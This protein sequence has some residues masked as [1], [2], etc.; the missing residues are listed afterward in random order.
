[1]ASRATQSFLQMI[2]L[3]HLIIVAIPLLYYGIIGQKGET[4]GPFGFAYM[5]LLGGMALVYHGY[6]YLNSVNILP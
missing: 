3:F 4:V 1:M 5:V 6:W 2:Y